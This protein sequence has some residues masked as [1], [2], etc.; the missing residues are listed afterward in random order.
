[1]TI[2]DADDA[3]EALKAPI[4]AHEVIGAAH[5]VI[6]LLDVAI[7]NGAKRYQSTSYQ[8]LRQS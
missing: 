6:D 3:G 7:P 5:E 8:R 4:E 2:S 1:M